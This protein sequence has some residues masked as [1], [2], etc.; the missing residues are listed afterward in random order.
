MNYRISLIGIIAIAMITIT[1]FLV[2][3]DNTKQKRI[4]EIELRIEVIKQQA[5]DS[6][7]YLED[8]AFFECRKEIPRYSSGLVTA[9]RYYA[10]VDKCVIEKVNN[11][12]IKLEKLNEEM[13]ELKS[14]LE[15]LQN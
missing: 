3:N 2:T 1:V 4:S 8:E 9:D 12:A 10:E 5:L 6:K 13:N 7:T 11:E 14:E 15:S